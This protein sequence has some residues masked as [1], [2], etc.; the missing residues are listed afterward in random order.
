MHA[1]V[2]D[3]KRPRCRYFGMKGGYMQLR[4]GDRDGHACMHAY[5]RVDLSDSV[6]WLGVL[7]ISRPVIIE[8]DSQNLAGEI[9]FRR[10]L[11]QFSLSTLD[12]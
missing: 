1:H 7:F 12:F 6:L 5:V 4:P 3:G 9:R 8:T 2:S 10:L 11:L